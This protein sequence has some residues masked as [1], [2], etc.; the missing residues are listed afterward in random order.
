MSDPVIRILKSTAGWRIESVTTVIVDS[1]S[2]N[3]EGET[4]SASFVDRWAVRSVSLGRFATV[5][6]QEVRTP[7]ICKGS[8]P[9]FL[10]VNSTSCRSFVGEYST[11]TVGGSIVSLAGLVPHP[12]HAP[13]RTYRLKWCFICAICPS[14]GPLLS[15]FAA[16]NGPHSSP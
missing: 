10:S 15:W 12:K 8:S 1:L 3:I 13:T 5:Q 6:L 14:R 4:F 7:K 9:L 16:V 2:P 11:V